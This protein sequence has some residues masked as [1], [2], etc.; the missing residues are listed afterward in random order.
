MFGI[1]IN[2][3]VEL[4]SFFSSDFYLVVLDLGNHKS[5]RILMN[6]LKALFVIDSLY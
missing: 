6:I 1:V 5:K 2:V 3:D 4:I